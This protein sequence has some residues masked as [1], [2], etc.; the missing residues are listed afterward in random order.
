MRHPHRIAGAV[1]LAVMAMLESLASSG[2]LDPAAAVIIMDIAVYVLPAIGLGAV[3]DSI[4]VE[5]R[6]R[7]TGIPALADD[8][9][10]ES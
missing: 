5:R 7:D 9:R 4:V 3:A 6:R 10:G 1:V 8:R 2:H